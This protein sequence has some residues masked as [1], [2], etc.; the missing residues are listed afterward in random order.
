MID[1]ETYESIEAAAKEKSLSI[2]EFV[3]KLS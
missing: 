2:D 3:A 1:Q